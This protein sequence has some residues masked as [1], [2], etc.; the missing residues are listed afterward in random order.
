MASRVTSPPAKNPTKLADRMRFLACDLES[1][2]RQ[3]FR[4]RQIIRKLDH[5]AYAQDFAEVCRWKC[6]REVRTIPAVAGAKTND[7]GARPLSFRG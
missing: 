6:D 3:G 4:V 7:I 1:R 5:Q 2:R